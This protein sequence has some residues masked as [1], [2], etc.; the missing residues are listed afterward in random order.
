MSVLDKMRALA[1]RSSAQLLPRHPLREEDEDFRLRYLAGVA[2]GLAIEREVTADEA[3]ALAGL[4]ETLGLSAA[5]AAACLPQR[6]ELSEEEL[7]LLFQQLRVHEAAWIFL[8]DLAWVQTRSSAADELDEQFLQAARVALQVHHP[9]AE[10]LIYALTSALR[11]RQRTRLA[12]LLLALPADRCLQNCLP[13]LVAP[14]F[15]FAAILHDRWI[16]HGD[17]TVTD[18]LSGLTWVR[19]LLGHSWNEGNLSGDAQGF[20]GGTDEDFTSPFQARLRDFNLGQ[21]P[22]GYR[23]WRLAT[24]KDFCTLSV[25]RLDARDSLKALLRDAPGLLQAYPR[26]TCTYVLGIGNMDD[27]DATQSYGKGWSAY[28]CRTLD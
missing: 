26:Y 20:T 22:G 21:A 18:T 27:S 28:V 2:L 5:A 25:Q 13:M 9:Q 15:G 17:G 6:E 1:N 7:V 8:L 4:A 3:A 11:H 19:F 10:T 12:S 14:C 24:E 16:D 23:D